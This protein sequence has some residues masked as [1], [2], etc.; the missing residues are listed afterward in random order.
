MPSLY[1]TPWHYN[2]TNQNKLLIRRSTWPPGLS[3]AAT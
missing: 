3:E 2:P 1:R